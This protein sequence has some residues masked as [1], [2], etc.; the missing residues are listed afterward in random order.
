MWY[1]AFIANARRLPLVFRRTTRSGLSENC[2]EIG[3]VH[4]TQRDE[5]SNG[6]H[7]FDAGHAGFV[8]KILPRRR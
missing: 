6:H 4:E 2:P 1:A 7:Y 3:G 8:P 5:G